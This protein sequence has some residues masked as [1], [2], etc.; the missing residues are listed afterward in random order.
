METAPIKGGGTNPKDPNAPTQ[1]ARGRTPEQEAAFRNLQQATQATD[2]M[3]ETKKA[4]KFR[5]EE[6][7]DFKIGDGVQV[8]IN[9]KKESRQV[10]GVSAALDGYHYQFFKNTAG[11]VPAAKLFWVHERDVTAR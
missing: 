4:Y 3:I 10:Q 9:G 6:V 7:S 2:K 11:N 5:A 1:E 8:M